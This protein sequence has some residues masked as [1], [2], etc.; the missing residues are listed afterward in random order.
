MAETRAFTTVCEKLEGL[1]A[2]DRLQARGTVR[3]AL[4]QAGLDASVVSPREMRVVLDKIL[5]AELKARG[6]A[7]FDTICRELGAS[8]AALPAERA[9][10]S[11]ESVF[12]R[13]GNG[14]RG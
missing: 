1:T 8:L 6:I 4:K 13:L 11:P 10:E 5:P 9:A 14:G 7:S 2:L 12:A 3:L